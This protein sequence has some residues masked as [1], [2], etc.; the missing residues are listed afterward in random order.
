MWPWLMLVLTV[1]LWHPTPRH[2]RRSNWVRLAAAAPVLTPAA[3]VA[4]PAPWA[5]RCTRF[6]SHLLQGSPQAARIGQRTGRVRSRGARDTSLAGRGGRS[7]LAGCAADD[8]A[9]AVGAAS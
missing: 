9:A 2:R 8:L 7:G 5:Y 3:P 6:G 1:R 4:L